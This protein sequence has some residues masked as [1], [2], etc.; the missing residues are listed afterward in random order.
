MHLDGCVEDLAQHAHLLE[1]FQCTWLYANGFGVQRWLEKRVDDAAVDAAS[2]QFDGR[3]QADGP[4][5]GDEHLRLQGVGH[6]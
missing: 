6:A 1:D 3:G 2:G 4:S 5:A